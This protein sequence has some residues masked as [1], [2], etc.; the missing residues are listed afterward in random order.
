[1]TCSEPACRSRRCRC[2]SLLCPL[3]LFKYYDADVVTTSTA[4]CCPFKSTLLCSRRDLVWASMMTQRQVLRSICARPFRNRRSWNC[5]LP[6][7]HPIGGVKAV[8]P[9]ILSV[10]LDP[11]CGC[12]CRRAPDLWSVA[13]TM[14]FST[15]LSLSPQC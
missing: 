1:V 11:S 9:V 13:S 7:H 12:N 6:E 14:L 15:C 3:H 4:G 5:S 2:F 10:D 8:H